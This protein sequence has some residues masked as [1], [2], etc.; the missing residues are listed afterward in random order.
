M[1]REKQVVGNMTF[2]DSNVLIAYLFREEDRFDVARHVLKKHPTRAI[3]IISIHEIHMYS[4][5]IGVEGKFINIKKSL[6]KLFKILPLSQDI[7]IKASRLRRIYGLP[8][9]DALILA[10]AISEKYPYFYT[11]DGD[12]EELNGKKV[13]G[14]LIH[15]LR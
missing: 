4:M 9:V 15:F 5:K 6:H 2:Y 3:S 1:R 13:E 14:T 12:F 8:E 7:C 11:F 10:T